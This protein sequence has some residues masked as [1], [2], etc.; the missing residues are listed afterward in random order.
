[1]SQRRGSIS[2]SHNGKLRLHLSRA[3]GVDLIGYKLE[4]WWSGGDLV[5]PSKAGQ[6]TAV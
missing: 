5:G 4:I 1:M 3:F 6:G 2:P